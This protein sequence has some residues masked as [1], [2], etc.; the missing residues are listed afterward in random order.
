MIPGTQRGLHLWRVGNSF[1][2]LGAIGIVQKKEENGPSIWRRLSMTTDPWFCA[3]CIYGNLL[4]ETS[5]TGV[6]KATW[7]LIKSIP[8]TKKS[9]TGQISSLSKV[10]LSSGCPGNPTRGQRNL[11]NVVR[12]DRGTTRATSPSLETDQTKLHRSK[13]KE[14]NPGT[15]RLIYYNTLAYTSFMP[16]FVDQS[17]TT[18]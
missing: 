12:I 11:T 4:G 14:R 3:R 18:R 5:V 15:P 6:N 16:I 9:L 1:V 10:L 13:R 2:W 17:I 7:S 8:G